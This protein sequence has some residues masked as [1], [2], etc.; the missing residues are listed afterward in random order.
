MLI[1]SIKKR[2]ER[3]CDPRK[4]NNIEY[5]ESTTGSDKINVAWYMTV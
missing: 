3:V 5:Y 1:V 4:K 2:V